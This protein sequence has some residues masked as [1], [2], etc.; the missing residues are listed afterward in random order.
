L[1]LRRRWLEYAARS[2][3]RATVL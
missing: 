2:K 1:T 3:H